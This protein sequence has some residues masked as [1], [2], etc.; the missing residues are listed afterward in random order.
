[1]GEF[2]TKIHNKAIHSGAF[3]VR[4]LYEVLA[5]LKQRRVE[6]EA[7]SLATKSDRDFASLETA[8]PA[9]DGQIAQVLE[10][11]SELEVPMVD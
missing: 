6:L 1:M 7:A 8:L 9:I 5:T 4:G 2:V 11:L 10:R 3:E